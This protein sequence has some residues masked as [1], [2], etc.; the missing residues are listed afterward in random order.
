MGNKASRSSSGAGVALK[1]KE[2]KRLSA[3]TGI[4]VEEVK[5]LFGAFLCLKGEELVKSADDLAVTLPCVTAPRER[6]LEGR[7]ARCA[8]FEARAFRQLLALAALVGGRWGPPTPSLVCSGGAPAVVAS[9]QL[10]PTTT[11]TR[12]SSFSAASSKLRWGRSQT[13]RVSS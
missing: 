8:G 11:P 5:T 12:T 4:E 13:T 1:D 3:S 6:R 10:L 9:R 7:G 2:V